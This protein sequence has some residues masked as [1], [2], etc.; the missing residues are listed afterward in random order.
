MT[1]PLRLYIVA[2]FSA[3]VI[4]PFIALGI[5]GLYAVENVARRQS[6][7]K[8]G[9][10]VRALAGRA[11]AF[12]DET[13]TAIQA[14]GT[15]ID[16]SIVQGYEIQPLLDA[17]RES[18]PVL[19]TLMILGDT[20]EVRAISPFDVNFIGIDFSRQPFYTASPASGWSDTFLSLRTGHSVVSLGIV[21]GRSRL[22]GI[23]DLERLSDFVEGIV[24]GKE[25]SAAIVDKRGTLIADK[26]RNRV[27]QRAAFPFP[28][29]V[30]RVAGRPLVSGVFSD[31]GEPFRATAMELPEVGWIVVF[32]QPLREANALFL[33]SGLGFAVAIVMA[34]ASVAAFG[35]GVRKRLLAPIERLSEAV[36]RYS[37]EG[38]PLAAPERSRVAEIDALSDAF[39]RMSA[40]V[41]AR[42]SAMRGVEA[43]LRVSLAQK[44]GLLRE[45][46][47]R[48][49]NNLQIISSILSLQADAWRDDPA[50]AAF[51][52]CQGRVQAMAAVHEGLYL[53]DDIERVPARAYFDALAL[54]AL[55][56]SPSA[57]G[58]VRIELDVDGS[59]LGMDTAVPCGLIVGEALSNSLAFGYPGGRAGVITIAFSRSEGRC[60]LEVRDDGVG[61]GEGFRAREP[62]A[63]GLSIIEALALQLK[64]EAEIGA[65]SGGGFVVRLGFPD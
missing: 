27:R 11:G 62:K 51:L 2:F 3:A 38:A 32:Y 42:E 53:S 40:A 4:L 60:S 44:D 22:V 46:H 28:E 14:A 33:A 21:A 20:G 50:E 1:R 57:S 7:E 9:I 61:P 64:A 23:I 10:I 29:L 6:E 13:K 41:A 16:R 35:L 26:D 18:Y 19:D 58:R 63:L 37:S 39:A 55:Q 25:G 45:I 17:V 65:S 59:E 30:D 34:A 24:I 12:L 5:G 52:E 15:L 48:V 31:R 47:H 49:K 8:L 36:A 54:M 56:S 43:R